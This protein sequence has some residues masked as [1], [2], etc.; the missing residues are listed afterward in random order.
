MPI[1]SA[2]ESKR[3]KAKNYARGAAEGRN[4]SVIFYMIT[5]EANSVGM[6]KTVTVYN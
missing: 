5:Q 6:V 2:F 4:K 3:S 1:N